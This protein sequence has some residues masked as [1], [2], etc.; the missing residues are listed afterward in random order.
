VE[1]I[2]VVVGR[3]GKPHGLRGE[4]TVDVRTDE[5]ARRFA[6]GAVLRGV[7]PRGSSAGERGL[8]VQATRDHQGVLLVT[9][10]EIMDR[11][12]AEAARGTVLHTKVPA[13]AVPDDPEEF[14][15]HQLV[16]LSVED[17]DGSP[18]GQVSALVHGAPRTCSPC[19]PE[20][21]ARHWCR[22][23]RLW[24]PR[25]TSRVGGSS[26]RTGPAWSRRCRTRPEA[27]GTV[28]VDVV[29]IFPDYLRP[30][31][32]S[33][34]GRAQRS[35]LLDLRVHDLRQ[36]THDRHRT[37]DDTPYGG[38]AGMVMRA[39]PWGEAFDALG[40][41]DTTVVVP[42]PSGAPLTQAL[43]RDLATR[44]RLVIACGRYEGIDA[45][46][47]E[48]AAARAELIEV[49]LGDYVLNGGEVAAL[50]LVE[51]VVRLLPG[52]MGNP[53]SL[54]EESHTL[55]D[56]GASLLEYP[57]YTKP[58]RWRGLEV[59]EVL[60]GG[61]H[62]AIA[63]WRHEAARKRTSERRPDLLRPTTDPDGL[64]VVPGT[65]ADAP[66]LLVLQ[67]ACWVPGALA[68]DLLAIPA[69]HESLEEVL[70]WADAWSIWV[71]RDAGR[72]VGAVRGRLEGGAWE[73]G[74]LMVAPDRQG[75]GLGRRLLDHAMTAAP[76]AAT[77][78]RLI[79]GE[80]S[81]RNR[82]MGRRAGFRLR[83][84]LPAPPGAVMMTR[85]ADRRRISGG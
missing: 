4:V 85:P 17:V 2:D 5:P 56:S 53:A 76:A 27:R 77:S 33:L 80:G 71:V 49:S 83:R 64:P 59:P 75:E 16:G 25:S 14:Y 57:V 61:N 43:A 15:D 67:R 11:T 42:T 65:R 9:F 37:V 62:A 32:L 40:V 10:E 35:G 19:V 48:H 81:D 31:E 68:N 6:P 44:E 41:E 84:D 36:W 22:S 74:R 82:R 8:T 7:P 66:E 55:S 58:A 26:W 1:T 23:S 46:V 60:L 78:Y 20:T 24:C 69:L 54:V 45:R 18:L 50:A 21:D 28:R 73:I 38:G 63:Q 3:I 70:A 34:P 12:A 47:L 30:L 13:D 52:F 39:E 29:S 51:A 79:T 72:L